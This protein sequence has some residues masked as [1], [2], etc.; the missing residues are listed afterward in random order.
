MK[1]EPVLLGK[2]LVMAN[3]ARRRLLVAVV[4]TWIALCIVVWFYFYAISLYGYAKV[5]ASWCL[6]LAF[7]PFIVFWALTGDMLAHGDEREM[8]QRDHAHFMAYRFLG[9][10]TVAALFA[11]FQTGPHPII[12]APGPLLRAI[13]GQLPTAVLIAALLLYLTLPQAI[14]LWTEPDIEKDA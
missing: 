1:T 2:H 8:H 5:L 9:S 6:F 12:P 10:V 7:V 13:L 4:Y 3:R 11:A 14:L